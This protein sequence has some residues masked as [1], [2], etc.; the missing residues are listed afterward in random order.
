MFATFPATI[1]EAAFGRLHNGGPAAFGRRP[2]VVES[3]MG[4]G[5]AANT[6]KNICKYVS[7][8]CKLAYLANFLEIPLHISWSYSFSEIW[9]SA[10]G[11]FPRQ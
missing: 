7:N 4:D 8:I 11:D 10:A 1:M 2:T 6:A 5:E 3:I 9:S